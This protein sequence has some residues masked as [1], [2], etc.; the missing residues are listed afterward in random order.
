MTF[1]KTLTSLAVLGLFSSAVVSVPALAEDSDNN[2]D[3]SLW[4]ATAGIAGAAILGIVWGTSHHKN[5][6]VSP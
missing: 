5:R 3:A 6:P 4:V 1:R 2:D